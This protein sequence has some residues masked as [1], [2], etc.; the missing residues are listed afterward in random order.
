MIFFAHNRILWVTSNITHKYTGNEIWV[1]MVKSENM[2]NGIMGKFLTIWKYGYFNYGLIS[3]NLKIWVMESWVTLRES[4]ISR[5]VQNPQNAL[6]ILGILGLIF[7]ENINF[8][9]KIPGMHTN[10]ILTK[11]PK[12]RIYSKTVHCVCQDTSYTSKSYTILILRL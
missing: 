12:M 11:I 4:K 8:S 1:N 9:S 7:F 2:G 10:I 3:D 5:R 6:A